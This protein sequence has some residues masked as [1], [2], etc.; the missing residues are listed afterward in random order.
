MSTI[1]RSIA[2]RLFGL[3]KAGY[4][5]SPNGFKAPDYQFGTKDNEVSMTDV[6][7]VSTASA[8]SGGGTAWIKGST[9][10]GSTAAR[11]FSLTDPVKSGQRKN[12]IC[13][14]SSLNQ[15]V[16]CVGA[17]FDGTNGTATFAS[18]LA[19]WR[20][21]SLVALS[22]AVWGVISNAGSTAGV[23]ATFSTS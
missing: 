3:D 10:Q 23:G 9:G 14:P 4:A 21:L 13:F 16:T 19:T 15:A 1:L 8:I 20:S 22:T 6:T 17:T 12:I 18:T 2:G 7:A 5:T 11:T